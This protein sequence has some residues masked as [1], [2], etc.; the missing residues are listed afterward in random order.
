MSRSGHS[1][2]TLQP[3][4]PGSPGCVTNYRYVCDVLCM[5]PGGAKRIDMTDG[6]RAVLCSSLSFVNPTPTRAGPR[7]R[8]SWRTEEGL[9]RSRRQPSVLEGCN[10]R[11]TTEASNS[12]FCRRPNLTSK[13]HACLEDPGKGREKKKFLN[14]MLHTSTPRLH[15]VVS[16]RHFTH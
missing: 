16:L 11:R 4:E 5:F 15:G 3:G 1:S 9:S 2:A 7:M 12:A 8:K 14:L 6:R 13:G 10:S